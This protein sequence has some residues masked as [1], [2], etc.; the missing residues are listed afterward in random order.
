MIRRTE[1]L[2]QGTHTFEMRFVI[3]PSDPH[4]AWLTNK[5]CFKVIRAILYI[6][7]NAQTFH[8]PLL[9]PFLAQSGGSITSTTG[10]G[11]TRSGGSFIRSVSAL[12]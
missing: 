8:K 3:L 1:K 5:Y 10:G 6:G 4:S 11:I 9:L 7:N 12:L 2:M